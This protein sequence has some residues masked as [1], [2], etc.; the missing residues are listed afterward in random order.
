[1]VDAQVIHPSVIKPSQF[2]YE[3]ADAPILC[4]RNRRGI[5]RRRSAV[6]N[7][8]HPKLAPSPSPSESHM[9]PGAVV[10]QDA[11]RKPLA[12]AVEPAETVAGIRDHEI[13]PADLPGVTGEEVHLTG[14][15]GDVCEGDPHEKAEVVGFWDKRFRIDKLSGSACHGDTR[16]GHGRRAG[17]GA[18]LQRDADCTDLGSKRCHAR[19]LIHLPVSR[20]VGGESLGH[21]RGTYP[22]DEAK[23]S[24][25]ETSPVLHS[26]FSI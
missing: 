1:M 20:Q 15:Y 11:A 3:G 22:S 19:R 8:V 5:D 10:D 25:K 4:L 18:V 21:D 2:T 6:G 14:L 7:T 13:A 9:V 24:D 17:H 16:A 12:A 26:I 23:P